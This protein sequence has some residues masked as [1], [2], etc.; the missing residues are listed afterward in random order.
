VTGVVTGLLVGGFDRLV[1]DVAFDHVLL[2][3]P[4]LLAFIP[5]VGCSA[6]C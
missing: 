3:S 4:W 5:G 2:L 1:V 6:R